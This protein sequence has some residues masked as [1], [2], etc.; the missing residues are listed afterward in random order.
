MASLT[1]PAGN[2]EQALP[3]AVPPLQNGDHMTREEFERR[4]EAMPSHIKAELIE[5]VVYMSSP[6]NVEKHAQHQGRLMGMIVIYQ[7]GTP[8]TN[9]ADNGSLLLS[10]KN[11]PQPDTM[12]YVLPSHG[13][14]ARFDDN[15]N[16]VTAPEWAGEVAASSFNYDL[17]VKLHVYRRF[18]V[19]EYV[20]WRVFDRAIDWFV[21]RGQAYERSPLAA[22][23]NYRSEVFPGLWLDPQALIACDTAA[24]IQAV[25]RGL[26]SPEHQQFVERLAQQAVQP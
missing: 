10:D 14:Q 21:L 24:A 15:G 2:T 22:D 9:I 8:G 7:G 16:M 23:G 19:N 13:G 20:V 4:Y 18:G 11:E 26:A 12:L 3:P 17:H 5:G 25:Q 6:V 1:H